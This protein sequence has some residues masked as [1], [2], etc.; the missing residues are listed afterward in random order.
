MPVLDIVQH[1]L[2]QAELRNT[3]AQNAA[4]LILA[5]KNRH[6]ITVSRHQNGDGDAG[7]AGAHDGYLDAV[8]PGRT[9]DHLGGI[10]AGNVVFNDGE[11]D[12]CSF[13][14]QNAVT[15]A[16]LFVVADQTADGGQGIIL[17]EHPTCLVQL[18]GLQQLDDFR[19]RCIDGTALLTLGVLAAQT[20]VRLV[21]NMQRHSFSSCVDFLFLFYSYLNFPSSRCTAKYKI[22][23]RLLQAARFSARI[24][25]NETQ[26]GY[27]A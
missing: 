11:M 20:A 19:N 10:G 6:L 14:A 15:L 16:L 18:V 4:D 23:S 2:G 1:G 5:F 7:R 21:H 9:L 12:R 27:P 3:V 25:G 26:R 24:D 22:P 8:G 13:S 17:K